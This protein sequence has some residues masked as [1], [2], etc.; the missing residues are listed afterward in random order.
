MDITRLLRRIQNQADFIL[1]SLFSCVLCNA[2]LTK[3][4]QFNEL[5]DV[6]FQDLDLWP[7][8]TDILLDKPKLAAQFSHDYLSGVTA[9][10][11][12]CWPLDVWVKHL[13]FQQQLPHAKL[14]G[15]LLS[16]QIHAQNWPTFD[17]IIPLPLHKSRLIERGFNQAEQISKFIQLESSQHNHKVLTRH[18]ATQAQSGLKKRQRTHNVKNAFICEHTIDG[19]NVLL[20]DDVLTT[21]ATLDAAAEALLEAGAEK[22]YA[23]VV[24]IQPLHK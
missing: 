8:G 11:K 20:I 14:L 17:I 9:L 15:Q 18:K 1:P 23:A 21:G 2:T 4:S 19:R 10:G 12:Y 24:A 7:F 6:C 13:K 3:G 16:Q 5:C 22:V